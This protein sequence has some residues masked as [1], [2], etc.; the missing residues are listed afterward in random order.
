MCATCPVH[1]IL[2]NLI[3]L[4]IFGKS[5]SLCNF[6]Q[7]PIISSHLGRNVFPRTRSQTPSVYV[8]PVTSETEF[9]THTKLQEKL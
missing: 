4:I 6:L 8:L 1:L 2:P 7:P 3:I 5:L 9:H